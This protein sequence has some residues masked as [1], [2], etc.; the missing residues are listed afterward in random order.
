MISPNEAIDYLLDP[1]GKREIHDD[2]VE[3]AVDALRK[4]I[5]QKPAKSKVLRRDI[6]NYEWYDWYCPT[7]GCFLVS[8]CGHSG[9][10][11]HCECGQKLDWS[12]ND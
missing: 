10:L 3:L 9:N 4:Q 2:S 11:H 6:N 12:E 5:P 1:I 7:C 8:G